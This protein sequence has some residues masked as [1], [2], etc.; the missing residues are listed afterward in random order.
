M[1]INIS[2]IKDA[3]KY[4]LESGKPSLKLDLDFFFLNSKLT[5]ALARL[6]QVQDRR[7]PQFV[8]H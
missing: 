5:Y 8:H 1:Q 7:C 6:I 2:F 3:Q 4:E